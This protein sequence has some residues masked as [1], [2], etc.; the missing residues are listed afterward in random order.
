[1]RWL[2]PGCLGLF[3]KVE[4]G[5]TST[6]HTGVGRKKHAML[7]VNDVRARRPLPSCSVRC[8]SIPLFRS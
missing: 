6:R 8:T 4:E 1:M 2:R 3:R 5:E 7:D